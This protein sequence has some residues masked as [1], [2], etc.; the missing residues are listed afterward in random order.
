MLGFGESVAV[1][2]LLCCGVFLQ[3]KTDR[4]E[5]SRRKRKQVLAEKFMSLRRIS[6][7]QEKKP[8]VFN[9]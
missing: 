2:A 3:E 5:S 4:K 8:T 6:V 1:F 7:W 9:Y